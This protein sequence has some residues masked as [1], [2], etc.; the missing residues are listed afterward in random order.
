[1]KWAVIS[2][3]QKGVEKALKVAKKINCDIYTLPKYSIEGTVPLE[4]GF[5]KGVENIFSEYKTLLFIMASGIVVRTIAP[6]IKSKDVDPGILVMDEEGNFVTSLLSGHLGGANAACEKVADIIGA[7]PVIS[8]ASDVSGKTAVDTIAMAIK[9]KMDSLEKA[10]EVT[11]LIVGGE[12]VNLKLPSNVKISEDNPAGVIVISNRKE[13]KIS[14]I[15]PH[16]IVVGIGCRRGTSK[17]CIIKAVE[18]AMDEA[19]LHMGSIRIFSTVDLKADEE[20]LLEAVEHYGKKI[21]IIPRNA[22][23]PIENDFEGSDFVKKSIGVRSVSAPCALL[24]SGSKGTFITEK[25]MHDGITVSIY[26]EEIR[27]DG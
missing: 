11:S 27:K 23:L 6:F 24:A 16:N 18:K 4:D 14:Q 13:I 2:V 12:R 1:M 21:T 3:T 7:V 8:T 25:M 17:E 26:E 19:N 15:I 5:K 9:G 20:G 10:K 22:I